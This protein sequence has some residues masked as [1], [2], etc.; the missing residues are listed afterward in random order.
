LNLSPGTRLGSY[1]IIAPLGSG[2]MGE[3]YRARDSRLNR[4]VAVKVLAHRLIHNPEALARFKREA[5]AVAA[6]SHPNVLSLFDYGESDGTVFAVMELLDGETLRARLASGPL[7]QRKAVELAVQIARGLAA[8][9]ERGI[10]HRDLK[11][12]NVFLTRDGQVKVLDFGLARLAVTAPDGGVTSSPTPS[13][14]TRPGIVMGTPGYMSPEQVRGQAAD[15]RSDIFA[16]GAIF[17]EMLAGRRAFRGE[18]AAE[19]MTAA[20]REEPPELPASVPPSL[21]RIV[22]HCL[23]K[24]R[25]QRF[26]SARDL[27][28]ALEAILEPLTSGA[29]AVPARRHRVVP[30]WMAWATAAAGVVAGV[31][32]W[33]AWPRATPP[34]GS[35]VRFSISLPAGL[36]L[37]DPWLGVAL[38]PDGRIVAFTAARGNDL[39]QL[40]LRPLDTLEPRPLPGTEG[41]N[42]PFWSPDSRFLGF[43]AVG[44]LKRV[45]VA[46]SAPPQILCDAADG[47]GGAW[48]QNGDILFAPQRDS[49]LYRVPAAGGE[50][51]QV[52]RLEKGEHSHRFPTFLPGSRRFLYVTLPQRTGRVETRVASLDDPRPRPLLSASS[53]A[54]VVP[55]GYVV[56]T[57]DQTV[58]A[59][60]LDADSARLAGE[61]QPIGEISGGSMATAPTTGGPMVTGASTGVLAF[62]SE[63]RW[64]SRLQWFERSGTPGAAIPVPA[65][66]TLARVSPDGRYA[67][68]HLVNSPTD[69]DLWLLELA[70]GIMTRLTHGPAVEVDPVWSPDS[71]RIAYTA[72][73]NQEGRIQFYL[74]ELANPD[75]E[76]L[77]LAS[78]AKSKYLGSWSRDGR[79]LFFHEQTPRSGFDLWS[80]PL[81][82]ARHP[83]PYLQTPFNELHAALS[84]DGHWLA[85][86]S[87]ESGAYEL[88]VQAFPKPGQKARVST[89]GIIS[90]PFWSPDSRQ[91]AYFT[92]DFTMMVVDIQTQPDFRV[93]PP[94]RLF[95]LPPTTVDVDRAADGRF[96]V[97]IKDS[98]V[99][100]ANIMVIANWPGLLEPDRR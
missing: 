78:D 66:Y 57:R 79:F 23:E 28:F 51:V 35:P 85:Y 81:G 94:R 98:E 83:V 2:G 32:G 3:V 92:P 47:R 54:T 42:M 74:R 71:R 15:P 17:Y 9:H 75:R 73:S 27:A 69:V 34:T 14:P 80:L 5:Q 62:G 8:A 40:W 4:D 19:A 76:E 53:V 64:T 22:C 11:P 88:Y 48:S 25:E 33:L 96:L 49:G 65:G 70:S 61:P 60:R 97:Q 56:F 95:Q 41:A 44:K 50:P 84:P 93:S 29:S 24:N 39:P 87:D 36:Q 89:G 46:G 82:G 6:L 7:S 99:T 12:E 68:F 30:A 67:A 58:F 43:F 1:E 10:V 37:S 20:L 63:P 55:G 38:S 59:Q 45:A 31:L 77:L 18:T 91:V 86:A 100:S 21:D 90:G 72:D 16:F 13:L 26:Q 52:T